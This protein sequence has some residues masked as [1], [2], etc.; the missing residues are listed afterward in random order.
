MPA[1]KGRKQRRTRQEALLAKPVYAE[2]DPVVRK[3]LDEVCAALGITL[4]EALEEFVRAAPRTTGGGL[5]DWAQMR[6][7][8]EREEQ[9]PL[10]D[11][12]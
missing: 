4:A 12:A 7:D 5:P 8:R 9:L 11:T 6:L 1:V 10:P 2:V 3:S